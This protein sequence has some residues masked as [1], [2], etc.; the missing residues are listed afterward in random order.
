MS[1]DIVPAEQIE[2]ESFARI[3]ELHPELLERFVSLGLVEVDTDEEGR[4]WVR[5]TQQREVDRIRRLRS[6]LHLSYSSIAVV[7]PLLDRV[8]RLEVEVLRLRSEQ[9]QP[10]RKNSDEAPEES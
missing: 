3:C 6:G 8:Q 9:H 2:L 1:S 7:A 4:R 5:R 10:V